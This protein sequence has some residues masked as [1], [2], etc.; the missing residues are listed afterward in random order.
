MRKMLIA[1]W[2]AAAAI[3]SAPACSADALSAP[4][5]AASRD[6][7]VCPDMVSI[8][9]GEFMM[10]SPAGDSEAG[11]SERPQRLVRVKTF[12]LGKTEVTVAQWREFARVSGYQTQAERNVQAQGCNTWEADDGAWAWREGRSWRRPGWS[13][14]DNE[15]VVCISW[16]DAQAYVR[17]LD[18]SS[19]VKGW[20]LPSEAEWEYAARAGSKTP[21]YWGDDEVSCVFAN[22]TD[23]TIGPRGRVWAERAICKD[24]Y[25]FAAPVGNYRPNAWGLYDMLGNVWE[26]VQDC[27]LPYAGAPSDGSAQ[28]TSDCRGR[29]LRGGAWDEPPAVLRS[30]ERFWLGSGNRN[31]NVGLRVARTLPL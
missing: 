23:R 10:G 14:K 18:Q 8:P 1:V 13:Q 16:V 20:R 17:W 26:W 30:A 24:G 9:G 5:V 29:V 27:F 7:D 28:E 3:Q 22:G 25:W 4:P 2:A 21:R 11:D 12:A 15:P 19:G 6:C 31:S